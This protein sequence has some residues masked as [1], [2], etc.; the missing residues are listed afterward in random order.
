MFSYTILLYSLTGKNECELCR[1][2][3]ISNRPL[4]HEH[5][6]QG[7]ENDQISSFTNKSVRKDVLTLHQRVHTSILVLN[8]KQNPFQLI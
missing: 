8:S 6:I 5:T 7:R 3:Y 2:L 4:R 1:K